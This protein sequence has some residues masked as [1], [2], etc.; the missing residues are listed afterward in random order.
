MDLLQAVYLHDAQW[1][2][3]CSTICTNL[4]CHK[5]CK[6]CNVDTTHSKQTDE[7]QS[8]DCSLVDLY[9]SVC[10]GNNGQEQGPV[11]QRMPFL[12]HPGVANSSCENFIET[13]MEN[14]HQINDTF[15]DLKQNEDQRNNIVSLITVLGK[16]ESYCALFAIIF[17]IT[18]SKGMRLRTGHTKSIGGK[19]HQSSG[20]DRENV[21]G[22]CKS[23]LNL[24]N[25]ATIS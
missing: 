13:I 21:H 25:I 14:I 9:C 8:Y 3:R 20:T 5:I 2:K 7:N 24:A 12:G 19:M 23:I 17:G 4:K 1:E 18:N 11:D 22:N 6:P 10:F 15:E 16:C